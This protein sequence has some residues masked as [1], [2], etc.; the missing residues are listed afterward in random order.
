[1]RGLHYRDQ[2]HAYKNE[3]QEDDRWIAAFVAPC[4]T[5]RALRWYEDLD[6]E[7][8]GSWK[9]LRRAL[10]DQYPSDDATVP[11]PAPAPLTVAAPPAGQVRQGRIKVT[12][13]SE[14]QYVS[15]HTEGYLETT[16]V[17]Q[18]AMIVKVIKDGPTTFSLSLTNPTGSRFK[19]LGIRWSGGGIL[20]LA[21][22]SPDY[23]RL[24]ALGDSDE[25]SYASSGCTKRQVW[26]YLPDGSLAATW[27]GSDGKV[28]I[29]QAGVSGSTGLFVAVDFNMH[30]Q[31]KRATLRLEDL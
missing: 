27:E 24:T 3:K 1:M 28:H 9:L 6:E 5:K 30:F 19:W 29:L 31:D 13:G 11:T 16:T 25:S 4:F 2:T 15:N 20:K 22:G 26:Q 12:L 23:A 10:L 18:F 17:I 8:Q 21:S 7:I 14:V